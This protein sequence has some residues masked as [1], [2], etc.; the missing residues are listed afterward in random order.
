[1]DEDG[2]RNTKYY[3]HI[4]KARHRKN[5]CSMIKWDLVGRFRQ[6]PKVDGRRLMGVV[7]DEEVHEAIFAMSPLK[8]HGLNGVYAVFYQHNWHVVG[9]SVINFVRDCRCIMD[10]IIVAQEDIH[11]MRNKSERKGW[12]SIKVDLEKEYGWLEWSFIRDTLE[13]VGLPNKFI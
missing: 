3:H 4:T 13:D 7:Q 2:D 10:N 12:M 9:K 8:V 6:L 5:I 11:S 1:M